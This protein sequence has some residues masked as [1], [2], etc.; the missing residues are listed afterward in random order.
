MKEKISFVQGIGSIL[1]CD[2]QEKQQ[3]HLAEKS[4]EHRI[5]MKWDTAFVQSA[6]SS[7]ACSTWG[8]YAVVD[9]FDDSAHGIKK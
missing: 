2:V 8:S 7:D 3:M 4:A 6:H 1:M 9:N 5:N